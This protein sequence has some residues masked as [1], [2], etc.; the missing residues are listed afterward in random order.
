VAR[1]PAT[2]SHATLAFI[3]LGCCCELVLSSVRERVGSFCML[4]NATSCSGPLNDHRE[5]KSVEQHV[6]T[7]HG[8]AAATA[9]SSL[10]AFCAAETHMLHPH[11]EASATEVRQV[12][13][14]HKHMLQQQHKLQSPY[15]RYTRGILVIVTRRMMQGWWQ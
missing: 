14:K 15:C 3:Y 13:W 2:T 1:L 12:F 7:N 10:S 5:G 9:C 11:A 6:T 4:S 8:Q